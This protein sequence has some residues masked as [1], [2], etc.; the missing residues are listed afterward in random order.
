[1]AKHFTLSFHGTLHDKSPHGG[2]E[3]SRL[4]HQSSAASQRS[5]EAGDNRKAGRVNKV[6]QDETTPAGGAGSE[7]SIATLHL[8]RAVFA[9]SFIFPK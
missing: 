3:G 9:F 2:L 4:D 7:T 8:H 6:P 5:P 1:M